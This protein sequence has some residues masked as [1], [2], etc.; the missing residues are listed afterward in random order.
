MLTS[1]HSNTTNQI[2]A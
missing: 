1:T 2:T